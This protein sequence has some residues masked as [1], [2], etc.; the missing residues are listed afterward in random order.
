MG[1]S[2]AKVPLPFGPGEGPEGLKK[3]VEFLRKHKQSV[4][5]DFPLRVDCY[6]SL[7]VP[8]TIEV[9]QACKDAGIRIDWWEGMI[10]T[11]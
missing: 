11:S 3:N 8:Y 7:N 2:G 1:F 10:S 4:G 9:V 5:D 6:M